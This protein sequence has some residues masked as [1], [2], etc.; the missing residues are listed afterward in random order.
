MPSVFAEDQ[1]LAGTRLLLVDDNPKLCRMVKEYLEPLGYE[2]ALAHTG[3]DGLRKALEGDFHAIILD[4]MLP[5]IDGFEVLRRLREHSTVPVLMLT[6]RGEPPDRIAG[7]ELGADDYVPK[8]FS[9]RELV[10]RLRAVIRRSMVTAAL[11]RQAPHPPIV[12]G[13]L[14][15]DVERRS[16]SLK[17][18]SLGLTPTEFDLLL[19]LAR[20]CGRLKTR[21]QLLLEVADRD[22]ET[23]D[24]SIDVHISS[25]RRKLGDD[26]RRPRLILTIRSAGYML[27]SPTEEPAP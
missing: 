1:R 10:A 24:R 3:P 26:P 19:S 15:L 7:L 13:D 8:T 2:V 11:G 23:F 27:Q 9:P 22:F 20:D 18:D 17:A 6:G 14:T 5:G 25:L 12:I 16:A 4:V 21:E